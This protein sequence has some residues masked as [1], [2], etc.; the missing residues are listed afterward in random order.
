MDGFS[1]YSLGPHW[2]LPFSVKVGLFMQV[3]L[4]TLGPRGPVLEIWWA[5]KQVLL[6][7]LIQVVLLCCCSPVTIKKSKFFQDL[8]DWTFQDFPPQFLMKIYTSKREA[9]I[10]YYPRYY[11]WD[12]FGGA[13]VGYH[14]MDA[15]ND[16][17][18]ISSG[19]G[20]GGGTLSLWV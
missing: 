18:F 5:E 2:T 14:L 20:G 12:P 6:I 3:L 13:F 8:Q 4:S 10:I 11:Y 15:R 19:R 7:S 17:C 16:F 9:K 1:E